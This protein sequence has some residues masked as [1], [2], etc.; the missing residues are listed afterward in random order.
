[1]IPWASGGPTG[2]AAKQAD[3]VVSDGCYAQGATPVT[4]VEPHTPVPGALRHV[5]PLRGAGCN[6]VVYFH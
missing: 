3:G 1:M 6:E 5:V 4:G 2:R